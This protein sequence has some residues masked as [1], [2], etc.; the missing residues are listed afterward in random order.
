M[1]RRIFG[2]ATSLREK[3]DDFGEFHEVFSRSSG[4]FPPKPKITTRE[5]MM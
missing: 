1:K 3:E 2:N 5:D 4:I